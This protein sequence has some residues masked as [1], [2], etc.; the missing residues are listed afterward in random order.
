MAIFCLLI[1]NNNK[2][3]GMLRNFPSAVFIILFL[4]F[5]AGCVT[6][7][8]KSKPVASGAA[9]T[10]SGPAG[11][12][13]V[14][15]GGAG[16]IPVVFIHS[17]AGSKSHW[18]VQLAHLRKTRRALALD[19]RGHGESAPALDDYTVESLA[20]DIAAVV[21]GLGLQRFVLV[22]HSMGGAAAIAYA[23]AHPQRVAGLVLVGAPGQTP[24]EQSRQI[25]ASLESDYEGVSEGYWKSILAGAEADVENQIRKE[26]RCL[27][28]DV[29]LSLIGAI[30][31][32]DPVPALQRYPGPKLL[33]D[34]PH[35]DSP[36]ALHKLVPTIPRQVMTDTSHWAHLDKPVQFNRLLDAFLANVS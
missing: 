9:R 14:D 2:E 35:G 30:L 36:H 20:Q 18:K 19:L 33:I 25:M 15:D 6:P 13:S 28:R 16:G 31:A 1:D 12:L 8:E 5:I 10:L 3:K 23:G 24:A 26:M 11:S 4:S 27:P 7:V 17:F 32:Y 22:G 29:S 21:D 34:T